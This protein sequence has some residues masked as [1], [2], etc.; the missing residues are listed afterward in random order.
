MLLKLTVQG[1]EKPEVALEI[2]SDR[3]AVFGRSQE[4]DFPFPEEH[5]EK[6]I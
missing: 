4:A 1:T 2:R 3:P 6:A 5:D